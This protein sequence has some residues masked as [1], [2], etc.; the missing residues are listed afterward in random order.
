MWLRSCSFILEFELKNCVKK[1][2]IIY[3]HLI[4][5]H[6]TG[7]QRAFRL[8]YFSNDL[9]DNRY[10]LPQKLHSNL[11]ILIDDLFTEAVVSS[12]ILML[13]LSFGQNSIKYSNQG[14]R[15]IFSVHRNNRSAI[16]TITI[17]YGSFTGLHVLLG[18]HRY[19]Q[20]SCHNTVRVNGWGLNGNLKINKKN[21]WVAGIIRVR[22]EP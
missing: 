18:H 13:P 22:R 4:L 15:R 16:T 14:K 9:W 19:Q 20:G 6:S 8:C 3:M 10:T 2:I 17:T 12:A 7:I 5:R 11:R 1:K 21:C